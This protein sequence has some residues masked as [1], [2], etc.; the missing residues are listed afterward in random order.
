M[1][2]QPKEREQEMP[3]LLKEILKIV[4]VLV[5][6]VIAFNAHWTL[7]VL[8]IVL[9]VGYLVFANRSILYAQRGNIAYMKGNEAKALDLL[10]KAS[11]MRGALPQHQIGYGFL[12]LK[13]GRLEEAEQ[14]FRKVIAGRKTREDELKAQVNL[15]TAYW[16]KGNRAEAITLL[17]EVYQTFKTTMVYGNL[18]Y[19][20]ILNGE[21]DEALVLNLAA[22]E[23]N[24]DVKTVL[25]N[26]AQNYYM[27]GRYEEAVELY[28]TLMEKSP[29]Y[30][31][32]FYYHALTLKQLGR[33]EE[34][35]DQSIQDLDKK[36]A[37]IPAVTRE[38]VEQLAAELIQTEIE[39][40]AEDGDTN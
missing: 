38:E 23:Y 32:S 30:A 36:L 24:P 22:Y 8:T 33:L 12:L 15:A 40:S 20:K 4:A 14:V 6:I 2:G 19:M 18:G 21:L 29:K 37:L 1:F 9:I 3:K 26:L 5:V 28:D 25:D 27:L 7:G 31:E 35:R 10:G 16:L 17:E 11:R 13:S 34:A 39:P